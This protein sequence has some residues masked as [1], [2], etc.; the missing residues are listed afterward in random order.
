M[1]PFLIWVLLLGG[2][3]TA[4]A[5]EPAPW[6]LEGLVGVSGTFISE[7]LSTNSDDVLRSTGV[8]SSLRPSHYLWDIQTPDRQL[9][10]VTPEGFWQLDFDLDVAIVR[11]VPEASELPLAYLWMSSAQLEAFSEKVAGGELEA[12]NEF[13]LKVLSPT[14]LEMRIVDS[15][16]RVTRFELTINSIE[17]PD[18]KV[19]EANI[20]T[21]MDFFDERTQRSTALGVTVQ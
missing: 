19:Y 11:D 9:L 4:M 21:G 3:V 12:I 2:A 18:L 20:L 10:L 8:F 1:I 16:S 7:T 5:E 17:A 13:D 15:L 6:P 14:S